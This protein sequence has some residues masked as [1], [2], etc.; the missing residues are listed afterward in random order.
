MTCLD[1]C[2]SVRHDVEQE[3]A[4]VDVKASWVPTVQKQAAHLGVREQWTPRAD[5]RWQSGRW[6][7]E[8]FKVATCGCSW[9]LGCGGECLRNPV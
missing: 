5:V 1:F 2:T 8:W 3:L 7:V 9:L 4:S 6:R